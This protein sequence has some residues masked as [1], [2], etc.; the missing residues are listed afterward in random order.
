MPKKCK[1]I[2]DIPADPNDILLA[3]VTIALALTKGRSR[4][5]IETLINLTEMIKCN[6]ESYLRQTAIN[7]DL[8]ENLNL[9]INI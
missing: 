5:E 7:E 4:Y 8:A 6:L 9:E 2:P 3:A 1:R